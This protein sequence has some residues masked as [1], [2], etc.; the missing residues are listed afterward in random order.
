MLGG[1][2][3][4]RGGPHTGGRVAGD[5]TK[6]RDSNR[7]PLRRKKASIITHLQKLAGLSKALLTACLHQARLCLILKG[8]LFLFSNPS[9][10]CSKNT[11]TAP[12]PT[13]VLSVQEV[14]DPREGLMGQRGEAQE[15]RRSPSGGDPPVGT[16]DTARA[17]T[18]WTHHQTPRSPFEKQTSTA[19]RCN[20]LFPRWLKAAEI[21]FLILV[22]N[23]LFTTIHLV[24]TSDDHRFFS[25]KGTKTM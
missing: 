8:K 20:P 4:A 22:Q 23:F 12:D 17:I 15:T 19:F 24:I 10:Q 14:N 1:G 21:L 11:T 2:G 7:A 25:A 9:I 18:H 16:R 6:S 13:R 3:V 5:E